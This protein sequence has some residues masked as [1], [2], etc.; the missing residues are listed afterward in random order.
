MKDISK[1]INI[2]EQEKFVFQMG[3]DY[4]IVTGLIIKQMELGK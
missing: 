1:I 3:T 4:T 2:M